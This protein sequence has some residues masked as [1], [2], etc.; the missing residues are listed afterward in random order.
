MTPPVV[1]HY[2]IWQPEWQRTEERGSPGFLHRSQL[3]TIS[4]HLKTAEELSQAPPRL[5]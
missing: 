3:N 1:A 5:R 2:I 4:K